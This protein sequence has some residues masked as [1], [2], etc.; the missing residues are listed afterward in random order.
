[1]IK[2]AVFDLDH[3]LFD[4]YATLREVMPEFC[5]HFDTAYGITVEKATEMMIYADRHYVHINWDRMLEYFRDNGLFGKVPT[6]SEYT[7][8]MLAEF[9]THAVRFPFTL[10]TLARLRKSGLRT[11]LIT[12]G[13]GEVQRSKLRMLGL[14]NSFDDILISGEFGKGKPSVEPFLE[15]ARRLNLEPGELIYAGDHP[16]YD[17]DA[18]RKAGYIP[19]WVKTTRTWVFP[20]IDVPEL[21]VNDVSELPELIEKYNY[22]KK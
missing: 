19:V 12:N 16:E 4:R 22:K 20:D 10:P 1:M 21:C 14:E 11:A 13:R 5:A 3:T 9:S 18:S 15:T 7:E 17:V 8:F 6:I 2:G